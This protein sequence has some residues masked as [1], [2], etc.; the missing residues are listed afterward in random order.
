MHESTHRHTHRHSDTHTWSCGGF[1]K[2]QPAFQPPSRPPP[3][4]ASWVEPLPCP[5][6]TLVWYQ[7]WPVLQE[8]CSGPSGHL[9]LYP[10]PMPWP[11]AHPSA[12][13]TFCLS[14]F[15]LLALTLGAGGGDLQ[16][17]GDQSHVS[18]KG[19][20]LPILRGLESSQVVVRKE[21]EPWVLVLALSLTCQLTLGPQFPDL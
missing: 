21:L 20:A 19:P 9:H 12:W 1:R 4:Q 16:V 2:S 11:L 5:S 3:P 8:P 7:K 14:S 13:P 17:L 15:Q 10:H 6:P 18:G